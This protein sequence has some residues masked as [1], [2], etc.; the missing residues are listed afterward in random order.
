MIY[1]LDVNALAA[2]G[3]INHGFHDR[4]CVLDPI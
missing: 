3:F 4:L 1:L 2:V